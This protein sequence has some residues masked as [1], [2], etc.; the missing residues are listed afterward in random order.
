MNLVLP[1]LIGMGASALVCGA[2]LIVAR[3][4]GGGGQGG[5]RWGVPIGLGVAYALGHAG[6][7]EWL[8]AGEL[9]PMPPL[10]ATDWLPWLALAAMVLGLLETGWPSPGW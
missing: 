3:L 9:P 1:G 2:V 6:A 7:V 4:I 8:S 10:N 5:G